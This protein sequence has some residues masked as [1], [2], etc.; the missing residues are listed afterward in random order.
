MAAAVALGVG[1][2]ANPG[3]QAVEREAC[4]KLVA[5]AKTAIETGSAP[6]DPET[7]A[8]ARVRGLRDSIAP[9]PQGAGERLVPKS[10]PFPLMV[11]ADPR[12]GGP[13]YRAAGASLTP[14]YRRQLA[15]EGRRCEW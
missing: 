4:R 12:D 7:A 2:A 6:L 13:Q 15:E 11:A 3:R 10:F 8:F 9:D 14:E 1:C 5:A